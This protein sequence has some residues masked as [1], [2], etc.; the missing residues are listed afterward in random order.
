MGQQD[1][2]ALT[3]DIV[4]AHVANNSVPIGDV[5]SPIKYVHEPLSALRTHKPEPDPPKI[6]AVSPGAS[7]KR[8]HLVSMECGRRQKT[9]KR[10]FA[11]AHGMTPEQYRADYGLP[12]TY[13]MVAPAYA[14][15][16][17]RLAHATGLGRK[18]KGARPQ[19]RKGSRVRKATAPPRG[20]A[21]R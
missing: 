16:Q 10:H 13:P 20:T 9:P 18:S 3:A 4:S 14:E 2:A 11:T 19:R 15:R 12:A 1:L 5:A 8:D 21:S 6:P 17:R 7:I